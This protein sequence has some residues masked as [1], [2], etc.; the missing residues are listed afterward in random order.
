MDDLDQIKEQHFGELIKLRQRISE[1][2]ASET[3]R[4]RTDESLQESEERFC[5]LVQSASDTIITID[6]HG[7]IVLWNSAAETVFGYTADEI[8]GKPF[9]LLVPER[10]RE[11][12]EKAMKQM[13]SMDRSYFIGKMFE[14]PGLR[15]DGNEFP[16]EIHV[17]LNSR[18]KIIELD[19]SRRY[20]EDECKIECV[21][22]T[23]LIGVILL[24][25]LVE[26]IVALSYFAICKRESCYQVRRL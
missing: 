14:F 8:V 20:A 7:K 2:E 12:S 3:R 21:P 1:L 18:A 25:A 17:C 5:S 4:K 16:A 24:E 10:L 23:L 15:K 6:C 22:S 13:V 9:V 19:E 11:S 26:Y